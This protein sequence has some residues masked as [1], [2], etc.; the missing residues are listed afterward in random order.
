MVT[1]GTHLG[2]TKLVASTTVSPEETSISINLTFTSV[3]TIC[4]SFCSPSLGPTSTIFTISGMFPKTGWTWYKLTDYN[5]Q[6]TMHMHTLMQ[7][8]IHMYIYGYHSKIK[9]TKYIYCKSLLEAE[10]KPYWLIVL[11]KFDCDLTNTKAQGHHNSD[12]QLLL[13]PSNTH[14]SY[15]LIP[16]A[17][18]NTWPPQTSH[19]IRNWGRTCSSSL[20]LAGFRQNGKGR[21]KIMGVWERNR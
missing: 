13:H 3:G 2:D 10:N 6:L 21:K 12:L 16:Y 17:K 18:A 20:A 1:C 5:K 14:S 11:K 8:Y 19:T 15:A 7:S 4:F 9:I